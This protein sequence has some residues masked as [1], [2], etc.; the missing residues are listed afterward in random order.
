MNSF[1]TPTIQTAHNTRTFFELYAPSMHN[2]SLDRLLSLYPVSEFTA[3]PSA[4]VSAE[5]YRA[6]RIL[7]DILMVCQPIFYGRAL[8]RKHNDVYLYDQNQ[9]ILTPIL[10]YLGAPGLGK[11]HTSEFAYMFGNLSHYDS[12]MTLTKLW[13]S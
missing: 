2:T 10:N 12:K 11:V 9:T 5:R 4:G 8:S 13:C 7:R 6:G 3:N 1:V